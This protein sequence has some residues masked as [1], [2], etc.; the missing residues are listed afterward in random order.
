MAV[1]FWDLLILI[2]VFISYTGLR[3]VI[4]D[5]GAL[6][7]KASS[8]KHIFEA[9]ISILG[10]G[11]STA[12]DIFGFS[13][14]TH[15]SNLSRYWLRNIPDCIRR[16][17]RRPQFDHSSSVLHIWAIII[18]VA[19]NLLLH[20]FL[21]ISKISFWEHLSLYGYLNS[22]VADSDVVR[23]SWRKLTLPTSITNFFN[24]LC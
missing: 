7:L 1:K 14:S 6:F 18:K 8:L 12:T 13:L 23:A 17:K 2:R 15:Y 22:Q 19:I 3:I 24:G 5:L 4:A 9:L 11:A 20:Q 16:C 10:T 21:H